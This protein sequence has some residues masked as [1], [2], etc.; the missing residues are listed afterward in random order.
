[1]LLSVDWDY[2]SGTRE[3]VFD[4]PLWGT[5]DREADRVQRWRARALRRDPSA[6]GWDA[7]AH[8]FPLYGNP[9]ELLAYAGLP[10]FVAWSH[11]HAWEWLEA[12][13]RQ[14]GPRLAV[15]NLDS[16][17]DLFSL[18]GDSERV[19][20]GNWAGLALRRDWVGSYTCA[21]P[22]W[23]AAVRVAE[24]F[25]LARTW[26]EATPHLAPALTARA[27]L[28]RGEPLPARQDVRALLLVQSPAWTNPA[29]DDALFA[30]ARSLN[31]R[32]LSAPYV[33][34]WSNSA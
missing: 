3:H 22:A 17:H 13:L 26:A 11:A 12:C 29:H 16:H 20:P 15:H 28:T 7:L 31:A 2:Y 24:G 25:D 34:P 5:P 9:G 18:S 23:H 21:Y 33:R 8:D 30:L 6:R 1:M 4:A 14:F 19:R 32:V 10:T 27:Q